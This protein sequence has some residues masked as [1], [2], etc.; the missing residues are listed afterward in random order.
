LNVAKQGFFG[1]WTDPKHG[2]SGLLPGGLPSLKVFVFF[3]LFVCSPPP[4]GSPG[5]GQYARESQGWQGPPSPPKSTA[6]CR[7]GSLR[8]TSR[9][10]GVSC[11]LAQKSLRGKR[12]LCPGCIVAKEDLLRGLTGPL[13]DPRSGPQ[14][15]AS[16]APKP[17]W[18]GPL[19]VQPPRQLV[20][21]LCTVR[22]PRLQL[23]L[24]TRD[25]G[26]QLQ[27]AELASPSPTAAPTGLDPLHGASAP[28]P[29]STPYAG[30]RTAAAEG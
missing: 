3:C 25:C 4:S 15:T 13:R 26:R 20:W 19:Q 27:K 17:N 21:I 28:A 9:P 11:Q 24:P 18:A 8:R 7:A 29:A 2:F 22:P 1:A 30:L 6:R 16:P 23:R 12:S 14:T 10:H 5:L